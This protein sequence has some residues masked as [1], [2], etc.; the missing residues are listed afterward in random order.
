MNRLNI[1]RRARIIGCLVEGNSLRATARMTDTAINTVV[2]LLVDVG[3]ACAEY[4]NQSL[5]DL[6]CKRLQCDEIWA[7]CYAK[8]KNVPE[9]KK[10]QFGYGDV[11]TWTAICADSKLVPAWLVG[12]RDAETATIFMEDLASRLSHRVQLTTDGWK[13]YLEAVDEAFGTDI[14][15]AMLVKMYGESGVEKVEKRYSPAKFTGSRK[16][17]I[18]GNP[19]RKH[20]STSYAERQN[21][22]MRMSMRRFT[23]L[24]NAFSKKVENLAHAVSLHFMYYNFARIH[25]TLRVTPAMEAGVSDHL[26]SLE[27]IAGLTD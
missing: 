9:D 23:R 17:I 22:T 14:D 18:A 1:E 2:K 15:Y 10:G 4:Q 11:W 5:R 24:T 26:W 27:E 12:T 7:F 13:S 3:K 16:E 6:K 25:K 20:I 21:L 19:E 8:A